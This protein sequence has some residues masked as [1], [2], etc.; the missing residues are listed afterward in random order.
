MT[1]SPDESLCQH[2]D[3]SDPLADYS[4]N[5][6]GYWNDYWTYIW[7]TDLG[8]DSPWEFLP[9]T[10]TDPSTDAGPSQ[11]DGAEIAFEHNGETIATIPEGFTEFEYCLDAEN[12]TMNDIFQLESLASCI[13][14]G[15]DGVCIT[16]LS[17]GG[18]QVLV[19]ENNNLTSFWIDGDQNYCMD[20]FMSS[21]QIQI[22]NGQVISSKCKDRK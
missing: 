16:S 6:N 22:Q 8:W 20:D 11:S 21:P 9:S 14:S 3:D 4:Y 7:D 5:W 19:G 17:I 2:P 10:V 13:S 18:D 12:V 1:S 15:C